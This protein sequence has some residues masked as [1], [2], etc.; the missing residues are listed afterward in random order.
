M[1]D[2]LCDVPG[3]LVGHWSDKANLTGCTAVLIP[4]GATA[5]ADVR[6]G[7][8]GTRET[9]L[10]KPE[11]LVEKIHGLLLAGGSAFGLDACSGVVKY[12]EEKGIGFDTGRYRVPI[13]P[14]AVIYDLDN[15]NGKVRPEKTE[16]YIAA[17]DA[18]S[19]SFLQGQVGA[20][21]GATVGKVL[22][23]EKA[24]KAGLGTAAIMLESGLVVAALVV[25]NAFGDI[26]DPWE[27][28][29]IAGPCCDE[30]GFLNTIKLM[31]N[32]TKPPIVGTNTTLAVVATNANLT[33]SQCRRVAIM[34]HDGMA[35]SITPAHTEWD[36]DTVFALSVGDMPASASLVGALGAEMVAKSIIN[37]FK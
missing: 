1:F 33:K 24:F 3:V 35:R 22:G 37:S 34:A 19:T 10:L 13:V 16:G 28:R 4:N 26:F 17:K 18:A 36:G 30:G 31:Q 29:Q 12:L 14:G 21:T 2:N 5:A 20:G 9:D 11:N 8:P 15:G 32:L 6:G 25:V 7:A 27:G 23:I